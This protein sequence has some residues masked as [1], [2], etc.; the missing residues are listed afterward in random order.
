MRSEARAVHPSE[1]IGAV[2]YD[3]G[4]YNSHT[5]IKRRTNILRLVPSPSPSFLSSTKEKVINLEQLVEQHNPL[6]QDGTKKS[7]KKVSSAEGRMFLFSPESPFGPEMYI[8]VHFVFFFFSLSRSLC[9]MR[10]G[11]I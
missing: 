3:D 5:S 8:A 11:R 6:L 1:P 7:G 9:D 2:L 10:C 4:P